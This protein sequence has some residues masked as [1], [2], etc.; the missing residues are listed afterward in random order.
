MN[1]IMISDF[2]G[3]YRFLSNF[4]P[5]P[6]MYGGHT[7]DTVEHAYQ[8]AKTLD[9]A[10]RTLIRLCETPRQAKRRGQRATLRP[11]WDLV[12]ILVMF[13]LL[14]QKFNDDPLQTKLLETKPALLVEGNDWHDQ[15]WGIC[16]CGH[17]DMR[18]G[19]NYLGRLLMII[20]DQKLE[21]VPAERSG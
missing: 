17:C 8:A 18:E 16:S 4:S 20:R 12:K 7:Y 5:S 6:L 9:P 10:E 15:V 1:T 14:C 11:D 2:R 3:K 19:Q 13:R 21:D